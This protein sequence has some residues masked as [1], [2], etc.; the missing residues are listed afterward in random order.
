MAILTLKSK[1]KVIVNVV[2]LREDYILLNVDSET[3]NSLAIEVIGTYREFETGDNIKGFNFPVIN[4]VANQLGL[5]P[6]PEGANLIETRN[7]QLTAGIFAVLGQYNDFG[8]SPMDWE[9]YEA[10]KAEE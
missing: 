4:E 1:K 5:V 8:L 3:R 9:V 7:I 6:I 10:P 2:S